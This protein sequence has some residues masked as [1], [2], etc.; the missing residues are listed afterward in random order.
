M[1]ETLVLKLKQYLVILNTLLVK[2]F[3]VKL[4]HLVMNLTF[5]LSNI[6][7]IMDLRFIFKIVLCFIWERVKIARRR[8]CTRLLRKHLYLFCCI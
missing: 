4:K 3:K 2:V 5:K 6:Y 7:F 1:L 8:N